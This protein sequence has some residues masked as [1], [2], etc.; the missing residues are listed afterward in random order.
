[1]G[2]FV[3]KTGNNGQYYFNLVGRQRAGN[4]EQ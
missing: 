3:T 1:M 4:S 2:K